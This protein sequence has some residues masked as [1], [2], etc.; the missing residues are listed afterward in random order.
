MDPGVFFL[1]CPAGIFLCYNPYPELAST[2]QGQPVY[3]PVFIPQ[4]A[5][6]AILVSCVQWKNEFCI[7][8][9]D[10]G[11]GFSLWHDH[12]SFL[13]IYLLQTDEETQQQTF[14]SIFYFCRS[15]H[16]IIW[17]ERKWHTAHGCKC[18]WPEGSV[19]GGEKNNFGGL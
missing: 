8:A 14:V 12:G 11:Q 4:G 3:F 19:C 7:H 18:G 5:C 2:L 16:V 9:K 15:H 1:L 6:A 10:K 13:K 17:P